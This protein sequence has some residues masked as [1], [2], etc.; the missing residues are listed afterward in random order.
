VDYYSVS[1]LIFM[2][3]VKIGFFIFVLL[4]SIPLAR[5]FTKGM[6]SQLIANKEYLAESSILA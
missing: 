3:Q 6:D 2:D 1:Q 4:I 5:K